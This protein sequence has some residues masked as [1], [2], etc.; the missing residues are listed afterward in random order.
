MACML[1]A[2]LDGYPQL[3]R[4]GAELHQLFLIEGCVLAINGDEIIGVLAQN[5]LE[6]FAVCS[7][8]GRDSYN[9]LS[10]VDALLQQVL[11]WHVH[12]LSNL[13]CVLREK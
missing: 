8:R 10:L 2:E 13:Q 6:A 5:I 11:R 9:D 4:D 7:D 3:F 12:L 1:D